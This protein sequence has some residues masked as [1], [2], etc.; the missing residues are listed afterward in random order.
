MVTRAIADAV[1]E[2]SSSECLLWVK[3]GKVHNEHMFSELPQIADVLWARR[4]SEDSL[5]GHTSVLTV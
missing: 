2:L 5:T 3:S 4:Q 1:I